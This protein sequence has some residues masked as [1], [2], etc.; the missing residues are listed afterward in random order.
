MQ[1]SMIVSHRHRF[2]FLKTKKTAGTSLEVL[3]SQYCDDDDVV[4][5]V[6]PVEENH[7]PRNWQGRSNLIHDL[8]ELPSRWHKSICRRWLSGEKYFNHMPADLVR[9]R[10]G[11]EIWQS[12]FKF[13][14]ERHPLEK[15]RSHFL[16]LRARSGNRLTL[17]EY[18]R[19]GRFCT[20]FPIYTDSEKNI[21]VDKIL[22]FESLSTDLKET[23][24]NLSID[25]PHLALPRAK[26][27]Y[28]KIAEHVPIQFN[29]TQLKKLSEAF[30]WEI[31]HFGYELTEPTDA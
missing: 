13:T 26:T 22:S 14:V 31:D 15:T 8:Y 25:S 12:Y 21:V 2:I 17:E 19:R 10:V 20:N 6:F 11:E 23:L 16:M 30:A 24:N 18:F 4:T 5:K 9:H 28:R 1:V 3:L 29:S 7:K 27:S